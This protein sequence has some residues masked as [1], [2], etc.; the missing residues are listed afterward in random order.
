MKETEEILA[1][2]V[3]AFVVEG[4][5]YV[6]EEA[7]AYGAYAVAAACLEEPYGASVVVVPGVGVVE[8]A[9]DSAGK[10]A[11][12]WQQE[13]MD[14]GRVVREERPQKQDEIA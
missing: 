11:V 8:S 14:V 2:Q 6:D 9:E 13:E 4:G 1:F 5:P 10:V 12:D 3:G 7:Q